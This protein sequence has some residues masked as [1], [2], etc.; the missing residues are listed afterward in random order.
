M[1]SGELSICAQI[2]GMWKETTL[3]IQIPYCKLNV[4]NIQQRFLFSNQLHYISGKTILYFCDC[5]EQGWRTF[6]ASSA[7]EIVLRATLGLGH[8]FDHHRWYRATKWYTK[9]P[10]GWDSI[11][12]GYSL[13][14]LFYF[15]NSVVFWLIREDFKKQPNKMKKTSSSAPVQ[16]ACF[17]FH[18]TKPAARM[19]HAHTSLVILA[20]KIKSRVC[21]MAELGR[22]WVWAAK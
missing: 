4:G 2:V 13:R 3:T 9:H 12:D 8:R 17:G 21:S 10:S 6:S 14:G 15:S 20:L 22:C 5:I 16:C 11:V 19:S 1:K 18:N 7:P